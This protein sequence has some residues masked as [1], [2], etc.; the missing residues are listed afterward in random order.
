MP[1]LPITRGPPERPALAVEIP[2]DV[3]HR[4]QLRDDLLLGVRPEWN[5]FVRPGPDLRRLPEAADA[6]LTSGMVRPDC[7]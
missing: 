3:K 7:S 2:A 6:S 1:V 5:E 4:L